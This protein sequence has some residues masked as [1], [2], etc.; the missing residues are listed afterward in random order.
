M[1]DSQIVALY[2]ERSE[3]AIAETRVKYGQYCYTIAYNILHHNEDAEESVNDTYL[4]AWNAMPPQRPQKLRMF[5]A[6]ITRNLAFD[7]Y[8]ANTAAKRGGETELVLFELA[9]SQSDT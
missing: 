9:V 7:K 6:K 2:W 3:Q 8:K 4:D 1:N 5:L